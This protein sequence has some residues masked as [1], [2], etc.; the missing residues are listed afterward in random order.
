MKH[1]EFSPTPISKLNSLSSEL[2]NNIYLKRED[3]FDSGGGGS[4][5]RMLQYIL[6]KAIKLK[7]DCIVTA[8]GPYSNFNRAL[9]LLCG[10]YNLKMYLVL[11]DKNSHINKISLNKRIC[12]YCEVEY[13]HS[14]PLK[15]AETLS[16]VMNALKQKNYNPYYIWGGGK[17]TE[18]V[19]AYYDC[20]QE[21]ASQV[22]LHPDYIVVPVGTGTTYTGLLIG[23]K[24]FLPN[25]KVIGISVARKEKEAK[26]VIKGLIEEFSEY[27]DDES[28]KEL[29]DEVKIIDDYLDGGYGKISHEGQDFIKKF[30]IKEGLI[31]DEIYVG[32][33]LFGFKNLIEDRLNLKNKNIILMNTGGV[34]NF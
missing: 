22:T 31:V 33:T 18:G 13:V 12:D 23:C 10:K 20:I 17:S 3:L 11:Y 9:A 34:Y 32:K 24:V 28:I 27:Y 29:N 2:D 30:I 7:H 5:A 25:T 16:K 8:G 6:Y 1:F 14:S 19:Y 21:I 26:L 4:K 15:V